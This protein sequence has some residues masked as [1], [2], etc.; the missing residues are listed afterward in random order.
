MAGLRDSLGLFNVSL[1]ICGTVSI[2]E[3]LIRSY[4]N[5]P[6][7]S[8]LFQSWLGDVQDGL[9]TSEDES[10]VSYVIRHATLEHIADAVLLVDLAPSFNHITTP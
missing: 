5:D 4:S 8:I 1:K 7:Y 6:P 3:K 10:T 2:D 9:H